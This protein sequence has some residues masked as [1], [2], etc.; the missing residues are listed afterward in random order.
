MVGTGAAFGLFLLSG[1]AAQLVFLGLVQF[2]EKL[3]LGILGAEDPSSP[4]ISGLTDQDL[5]A[6][7]ETTDA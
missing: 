6:S 3:E 1:I 4:L 2:L 5:R 7:S